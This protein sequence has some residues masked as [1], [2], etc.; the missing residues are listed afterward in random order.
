[1]RP[2][3]PKVKKQVLAEPK[4]CLRSSEKDCQGRLTLEHAI[5][6]AGRQI[7]APWA[8]LMICEFHHSVNRFQDGGKMNKEKHVWLAL[9]RATDRE[10]TEISQAIDYC[11]LRDRLN[12]KY[13]KSL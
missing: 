9:N 11:A 4:M 3:S 5:I 6:H 13:S 1:M 2:I 10:L 7:D 8:I 12:R